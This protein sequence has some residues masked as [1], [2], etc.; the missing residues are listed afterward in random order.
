[1]SAEVIQTGPVTADDVLA[2]AVAEHG[3][4][5]VG[6]YELAFAYESMQA[7]G[8]RKKTGVFYTPAE[9]AQTMSTM[10]L[11]LGLN[12]CGESPQQVL[13][14]LALDPACGCGQFLVEAARFLATE[15]ARRL[16]NEE[17]SGD[18]ILAVMPRIIL[19]CIF[20]MDID[21]VAVELAKRALSLET[22]GAVTPAMLDRHFKVGNSVNGPDGP[23]AF[24]DRRGAVP[25]GEG[26]D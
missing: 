3:E 2:K 26:G 6:V 17:P 19:E 1:M 9:V 8:A 21:P 14:I 24:E 5:N 4:D 13:K 18:L 11:Q 22:V 15:Y 12:Q 16:I 25:S 7:M 20:G 23:P 10:S